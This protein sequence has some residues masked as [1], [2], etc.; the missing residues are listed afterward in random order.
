MPLSVCCVRSEVLPITIACFQHYLRTLAFAPVLSNLRPRF[1]FLNP[2]RLEAGVSSL[3]ARVSNRGA[4]GLSP[5]PL[6][7]A[8]WQ[9][10]TEKSA[11]SQQKT[12]DRHFHIQ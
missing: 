5:L 2:L 12:S 9:R 8:S 3:R 1:L 6:R 10:M 4:K 11:Y 7:W